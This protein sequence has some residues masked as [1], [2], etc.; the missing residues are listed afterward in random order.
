MTSL[1]TNVRVMHSGTMYCGCN[2]H[3]VASECFCNCWKPINPAFPFPTET[4]SFCPHGVPSKFNNCIEC[5][6]KILDS[7]DD[8]IATLD[9]KIKSLLEIIHKLKEVLN[10]L[11]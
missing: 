6:K 7:R 11:D 3:K 10:E 2:C 4:L 1:A 8:I 9:Q 5:N